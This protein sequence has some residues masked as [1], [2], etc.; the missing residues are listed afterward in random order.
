MGGVAG[1]EG[2]LV[3]GLN[4]GWGLLPPHPAETA[5]KSAPRK[6]GRQLKNLSPSPYSHRLC[7]SPELVEE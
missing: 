4:R 2:V 5:R 7:V 6:G 1:T 3:G